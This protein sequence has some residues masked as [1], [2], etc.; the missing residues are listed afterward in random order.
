MI[1][2]GGDTVVLY[3]DIVYQKNVLEKLI[4][5]DEPIGLVIDRQWESY[6]RIRMEDPLVD[7]ETLRL[8][9]KGRV[10]ELGK[11][12]S[13]LDDIQGQYVGMIKFQENIIDGIVQFY[14]GLDRSEM[15]DG[16]DFDNMYMTS[17]LQALIN[18][19]FDVRAVEIENGWL[20]V[21]SIQDLEAYN[22]LESA[23][24]LRFF[25]DF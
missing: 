18:G 5:Y 10:L 3:G 16:K 6:W 23:G 1:R 12:P 22:S 17:F 25:Y 19:G 21:D 20:E 24:E 7:A 11:K 14:H 8:E 9:D 13:S 4:L 15:F 2:S